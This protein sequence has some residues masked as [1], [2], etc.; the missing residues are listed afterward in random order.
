MLIHAIRHPLRLL[1]GAL[2]AISLLAGLAPLG[3]TLTQALS[4]DIVIS[5][6]YGGGGETDA[7]YRSDFVEL[8]NRGTG[9][10]N[11]TGWSV[12]LF[13]GRLMLAL[14]VVS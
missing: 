7:T 10:I 8:F 9:D 2:L 13:T 5:Q 14:T 6:V 1:A 11:V 3:A 12:H 4:P